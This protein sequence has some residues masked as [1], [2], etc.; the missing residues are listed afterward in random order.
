MSDPIASNRLAE[1][2]DFIDLVILF[3][4]CLATGVY[5][6][7]TTVVISNDGVFYIERARVFSSDP[8]FIKAHPPEYPFLIFVAHR[9]VTLFNTQFIG[10]IFFFWPSVICCCY[11]GVEGVN[12]FS[13]LEQVCFRW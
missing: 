9:F 7:V 12:G 11:W 1:R 5:L 13:F 3:L 8:V 2:R 4:I 10:R 6:I